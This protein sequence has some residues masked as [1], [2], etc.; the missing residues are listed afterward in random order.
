M[1]NKKR[2]WQRRFIKK[3]FESSNDKKKYFSKIMLQNISF[4]NEKNEYLPKYL[5]KYYSPTSENILD[6]K[7]QRLWLSHPKSFNDPFDCNIGYDSE[8]YEKN[9]LVKFI[10]ENGCVD[11]DKKSE[12][13]TLTDKNRIL[14]SRLG[15]YYSMYNKKESYSDAKWKILETKSEEFQSK[16]NNLLDSKL[17]QIDY[18]IEKLKNLNIRVACFSELKRY[19]EF[20]NQI[21]MWS[22]YA[23][24]HKGFCIEYDLEFLKKDLHFSLNDREFYFDNKNEYLSERNKAIIKAGLFPIEYTSNRVNIPVT[25]LNQIDI[26]SSGKI[27]YNSNI[28]ELFYKTFVVKSVNWNYEK[29]WRII[30][31]GQISSYYDNKI[32]FP[33]IKTIYLGCKADNELINTM[34]TIGEEIG[35]EVNIL[36]MDGKKFKLESTG[37][38]SYKYDRDKKQWNNPY[39]Y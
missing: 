1:R 24:N 12:G 15:D 11:E 36:K 20:P 38:W 19:D 27:V 13:F 14:S 2:K 8:N 31:D 10:K 17:Q 7:N 37:T 39:F 21:V 29:E 22:H 23:D 33:Y 3:I 4:I 26:D 30:I 35:A 9:C 28:D 6:I 16:I 5:F 18:K 32:P 25:K 34:I